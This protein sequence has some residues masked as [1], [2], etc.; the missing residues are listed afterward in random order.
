MLT[1]LV[2]LVD[3]GARRKRPIYSR[4]VFVVEPHRRDKVGVAGVGLLFDVTPVPPLGS[5]KWLAVRI[6]RVRVMTKGSGGKRQMMDTAQGG[7][8]IGRVKQGGWLLQ[9][10]CGYLPH[11]RRATKTSAATHHKLQIPLIRIFS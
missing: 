6:K 1:H 11:P 5:V 8:G 3:V 7:V 10:W 9:D 2:L 4:W